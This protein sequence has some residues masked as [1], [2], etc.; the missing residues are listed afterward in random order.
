MPELDKL[1]QIA[2]IRREVFLA[3]FNPFRS[4]VSAIAL[5]MTFCLATPD[6][7]ARSIQNG[8]FESF[9]QQAWR[10]DRE[11]RRLLEWKKFLN[12]YELIGMS[13]ADLESLL[14]PAQF[15]SNSHPKVLDMLPL[16]S[17]APGKVA[18]YP[19][20]S[21]TSCGRGSHSINILLNDQ[22]RVAAW[23]LNGMSV[24]NLWFK[25]NVV[26]PVG[27]DFQFDKKNFGLIDK[28]DLDAIDTS[29]DNFLVDYYKQDPSAILERYFYPKPYL[30]SVGFNTR[31][32]GIGD[33][34]GKSYD[35][36][37]LLQGNSSVVDP[38]LKTWRE[39]LEQKINSVFKQSKSHSEVGD[40]L[41]AVDTEFSIDGSGRIRDLY[42]DI[43]CPADFLQMIV[44]TL[45][46]C[47]GSEELAL[48]DDRHE[49]VK[50]NSRFIQNFGPKFIDKSKN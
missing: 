33:V 24:K 39:G 8:A 3:L 13:K 37:F 50:I 42:V 21:T 15:N 4:M 12:Q 6:C 29:K 27:K 5:S 1:E 30:C 35:H 41:L 11:G 10:E 45:K 34:S 47:Q 7:M 25:R 49:A 40:R 2:S 18:S 26:F 16:P 32:N 43:H 44:E 31:F 22:D 38:G 9:H 28:G 48:P 36:S 19:L 20:Y 17:V 14:G 46:S 23:R